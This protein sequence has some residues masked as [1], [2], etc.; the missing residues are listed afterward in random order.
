[1]INGDNE[2]YNIVMAPTALK[3]FKKYPDKL[4]ERI[5]KEVRRIA[6][7]P[8]INEEL[9]VPLKGIRS[10]HFTHDSIQYRIAYQI[11]V[12]SREIEILLVKTRENFYDKLFRIYR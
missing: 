2:P 5:K 11:N 1:M 4:K 6:C 7:D 8:Y 3:I 10:Y 12:S 9:S